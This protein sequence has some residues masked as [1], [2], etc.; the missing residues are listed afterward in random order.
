MH[1]RMEKFWHNA[2]HVAT[3]FYHTL[4]ERVKNYC[5]A[6]APHSQCH[7]WFARKKLLF[8]K[9]RIIVLITWFYGHCLVLFIMLLLH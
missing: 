3:S 5:C 6:V 1:S 2:F 7:I 8:W 4:L 9:K